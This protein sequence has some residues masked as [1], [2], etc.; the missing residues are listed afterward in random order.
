MP[1]TPTILLVD[2]SRFFLTLERQFLQS[3]PANIVEVTSAE[4]ALALC[5]RKKPDLIYMEYGL[6]GICGAEC[7]LQLKADPDLRSIPVILLCDELRPELADICRQSG[8]DGFLAKPLDRRRFLEL[9]RSLLAGIREER[10]NCLLQV[11]FRRGDRTF[12][13]KGLDISNG[14]IFLES[15]ET[16]ETGEILK[17]EIQLSRSEEQGP[18]IFCTGT[19]VWIN[20]LEKPFKPNHPEGYGVKFTVTTLQASGVLNG[21]LKS[22]E[23]SG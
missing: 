20:T 21:F 12:I 13:A 9:G 16:L 19:V 17:L 10:K 22:L 6:P 23:K 18:W 1:Q 8:C 4:Q 5:R 11:R 14:G 3:T 15:S 7:C 2:D